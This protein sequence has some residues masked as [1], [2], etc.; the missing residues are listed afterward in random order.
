MSADD[1]ALGYQ[2]DEDA[3]FDWERWGRSLRRARFLLRTFAIAVGAS[4]GAQALIGLWRWLRRP[5]GG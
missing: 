1:R 3:G 2:G 4:L 5:P